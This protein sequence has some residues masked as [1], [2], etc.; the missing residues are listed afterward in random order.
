MHGMVTEDVLAHFKEKALD[1]TKPYPIQKFYPF[2]W[3]LTF[4]QTIATD[5]LPN[6]SIAFKPELEDKNIGL[7]FPGKHSI[8]VAIALDGKQQKIDSETIARVLMHESTHALTNQIYGTLTPPEAFWGNELGLSFRI[9]LLSMFLSPSEGNFMQL[10]S[11]GNRDLYTQDS[12]PK[13]FIAETI[14][15]T[16]KNGELPLKDHLFPKDKEKLI[17]AIETFLQNCETYLNKLINESGLTNV[18]PWLAH[19]DWSSPQLAVPINELKFFMNFMRTGSLWHAALISQDI[20]IVEK[21]SSVYPTFSSIF[22]F[23]SDVFAALPD[24]TFKT[25]VEQLMATSSTFQ[26]SAASAPALD[27]P[28]PSAPSGELDSEPSNPLDSPLSFNPAWDGESN[29]PSTAFPPAF[30]PDANISFTATRGMRFGFLPSLAETRAEPEVPKT[31][32]LFS[33]L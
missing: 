20:A 6:L 2:F 11:A 23:P 32:G 28:V 33:K 7:Y 30:N 3:L 9:S 19:C 22:A 1:T 26:P 18:M 16:I 13:E 24:N 17:L 12:Y 4:A 29:P 10:Y 14:A 27:V 15:Y 8:D 31:P 5:T 21:L 25:Q